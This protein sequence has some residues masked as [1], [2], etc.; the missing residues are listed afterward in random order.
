MRKEYVTA[1]GNSLVRAGRGDMH[2]RVVCFGGRGTAVVH[3]LLHV[4]FR[5]DK[6]GRKSF[7]LGVQALK[8]LA[9][10]AE[11]YAAARLLFWSG[12]RQAI[13][14]KFVF[15]FFFRKTG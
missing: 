8:I 7:S 9:T 10:H 4:T 2:R 12:G 1:T 13:A 15:F 5:E 6:T 3:V 14:N 11:T